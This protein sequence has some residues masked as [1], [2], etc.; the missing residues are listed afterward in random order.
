M[1][2]NPPPTCELSFTQQ[3]TAV[4]NLDGWHPNPQYPKDLM[5][6]R[7]CHEENTD[8]NLWVRNM[9]QYKAGEGKSKKTGFN[10]DMQL[11]NINVRSGTGVDLRF[12]FRSPGRFGASHA[13]TIGSFYITLLDL[14]AGQ[15]VEAAGFKNYT[16]DKHSKIQ[17]TELTS[18]DYTVRF[19]SLAGK[20]DTPVGGDPLTEAQQE[21][22]VSLYFEKTTKFNLRLEVKGADDGSGQNFPFTAETEVSR[23]QRSTASD[24]GGF[25]QARKNKVVRVEPRSP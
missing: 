6:S 14:E 25:I 10:S 18:T 4:S 8:V 19:E 16:L 20:E 9:S 17:V 2:W 24:L 3:K 23:V 5:F 22:G 7:V 1:P 12:E 11:P 15:V 13:V 21:L